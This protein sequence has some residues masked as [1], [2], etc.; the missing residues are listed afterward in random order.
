MRQ[1]I[2]TLLLEGNP[3]MTQCHFKAVTDWNTF[4]G[5]VHSFETRYFVRKVNNKPH[6]QYSWRVQWILSLVPFLIGTSCR[7]LEHSTLFFGGLLL[8]LLFC[9]VYVHI[10][11]FV[12]RLPL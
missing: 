12:E 2:F 7:Y 3:K 9:N 1:A 8:L 6:V 5:T 11:L 10:Y 4:E